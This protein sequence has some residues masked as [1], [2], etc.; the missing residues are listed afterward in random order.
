MSSL[1]ADDVEIDEYFDILF[2]NT[3]ATSLLVES[4]GSDADAQQGKETKGPPQLIK[5]IRIW[6]LYETRISGAH[7]CAPSF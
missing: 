3:E 7:K 6:L 5:S 1:G 4:V 2:N